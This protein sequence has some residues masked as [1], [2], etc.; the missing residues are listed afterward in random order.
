MQSS[1]LGPSARTR[2][3]RLALEALEARHLL[4]AGDLLHTLH[5]G[6]QS[7]QPNEFQGQAVAT[8]G[9]LHVVGAPFA[10]LA[11]HTGVGVVRV[12]E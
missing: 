3:A 5:S 12:Y 6:N 8:D 1:H 2:R 4:A 10:D 7:P 9:G 11:E